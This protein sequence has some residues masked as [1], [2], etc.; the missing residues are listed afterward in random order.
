[1]ILTP[2][3]TIYMRDE[4]SSP[5]FGMLFSTGCHGPLTTH[6]TLPE[7]G[8]AAFATPPTWPLFDAAAA[9]GRDWY[10][11]DHGYFNRKRHFRV[12]RNAIQHQPT[13][14]EILAATPVR[15]RACGLN[16]REQWQRTGS[17]ILICPNS[18]VYHLRWGRTAAAWVD[19]VRGMLHGVTDRPIVVRSKAD[20]HVRSVYEDL[21][22]AWITIVFS[23]NCAVDSLRAG[24]PIATLAPFA[25]TYPLALHD[26]RAVETPIYPDDRVP[27]LWALADAQWTH[28]EVQSGMAWRW[29]QEHAILPAPVEV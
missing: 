3:T 9:E 11:G 5:R 14:D 7:G 22:D 19:E 6:L 23:S 2:P 21:N 28:E 26:L 8:I 17:H 18:D 15:Y 10:Y 29:L 4:F 16:V 1:M 20:A 24:V 27:F 12:S 25:S 13:L